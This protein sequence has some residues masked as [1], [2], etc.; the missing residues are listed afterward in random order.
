MMTTWNELVSEARRG[1]ELD[2]PTPE[3]RVTLREW[4]DSGE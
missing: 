1:L 3:D 4:E 2:Y